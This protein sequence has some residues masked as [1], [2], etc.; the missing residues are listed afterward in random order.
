MLESFGPLLV[1][2]VVGFVMEKGENEQDLAA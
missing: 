1:T 2:V